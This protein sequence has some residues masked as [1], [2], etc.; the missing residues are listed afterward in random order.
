MEVSCIYVNI[1]VISV[2]LKKEVGKL[3]SGEIGRN[4]S[5]VFCANVTERF[6]PF[7]F[8]SP[9]AKINQRLVL[10]GPPQPVAVAK[11]K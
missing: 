4:V 10:K 11:N 2:R 6:V 5:S 3:T 8:V 7:V 9:R 1:E